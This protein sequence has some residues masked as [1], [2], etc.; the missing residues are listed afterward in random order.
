MN[1]RK[2]MTTLAGGVVAAGYT[3]RAAA[4]TPR[5]AAD[6]KLPVSSANAAKDIPGAKELPDPATDYKVVFSVSA[7]AKPDEVHPTLK[8]IG[9]YLNTL[10]H[11][12]VPAHNRHIAAMFHQG[13]GDAVL[14]NDVYKS[15]HDGV[16]NPN[17]AALK[18]LQDAGVTL[19]VCGQGLLGKKV[20]PTQ[21]LPGVQ[22][23]LWAM[24]TMVNLQTRGY[25]RVGG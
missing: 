21:V 1:R 19:H 5:P 6:S 18:E 17:V 20:D 16:D 4:G 25:V 8:M 24:V 7:K 12:G 22:V 23:D 2:M 14:S 10:A 9:L 15:R 11:N 3:R 13:G